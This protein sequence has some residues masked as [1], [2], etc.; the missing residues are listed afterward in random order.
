MRSQGKERRFRVAWVG[1]RQ[2]NIRLEILGVG[3]RSVA[4][5]AGD[6]EWL[7]YYSHLEKQLYKERDSVRNLR[8]LFAVPVASHDIAALLAGRIPIREHH[9]ATLAKDPAQGIYTLTLTKKWAGDV[10]RIYLDSSELRVRQMEMLNTRQAVIYRV[11]FKGKKEIEA[12][13]IP[14][15]INITAKEGDQLQIDI[16]RYWANVP[17]SPLMFRIKA[18]AQ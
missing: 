10:E 1:S 13:V 7:Y 18:P 8:R 6:G 3:G 5:L 2:G 16:E 4:S 15:R 11:Q 17:V 14:S 9:R 12:F